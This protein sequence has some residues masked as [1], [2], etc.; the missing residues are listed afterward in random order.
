MT[1]YMNIVLK[2]MS[3]A[4]CLAYVSR[5]LSVDLLRI[6][7]QKIYHFVCSSRE[8]QQQKKTPYLIN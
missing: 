3:D 6:L 1:R 7:C 8:G 5:Y 2:K 4:L